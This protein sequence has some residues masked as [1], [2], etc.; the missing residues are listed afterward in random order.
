MW[1]VSPQKIIAEPSYIKRKEKPKKNPT[2]KTQK[3]IIPNGV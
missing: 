2:K 3:A 1:D